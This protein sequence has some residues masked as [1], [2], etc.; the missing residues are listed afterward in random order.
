MRRLIKMSK[1]R[2]EK[3]KIK[4]FAVLAVICLLCFTS[5]WLVFNEFLYVQIEPT[6]PTEEGVTGLSRIF[7]LRTLLMFAPLLLALA[8][9]IMYI[10]WKPGRTIMLVQKGKE[11]PVVEES[12]GSLKLLKDEEK[13]VILAIARSEGKMLQRELATITSLPSYKVTRILNRLE[14]LRLI[15]RKRYGMTNMVFLNFDSEKILEIIV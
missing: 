11:R 2:W 1:D 9:A 13:L 4:K 7:G 8:I 12:L 3:T 6:A 14:R 5:L 15:T 10:C